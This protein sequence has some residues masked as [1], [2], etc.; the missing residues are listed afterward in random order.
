MTV[1]LHSLCGNGTVDSGQGEQ[2][3]TGI[4]G[5][6]CCNSTCHFISGGIVPSLR[7][8]LRRRGELLGLGGDLPGEH[9]R[10]ERDRVSRGHGR[11]L[12]RGRE[13]HRLDGSLSRLTASSAVLR[14]AAPTGVCDVVENCTGSSPNCPANAFA[15]SS[16]TCRP[17]AGV[18]DVA[19]NCTGSSAACPANTFASNST[20][21]P[22]RRGH[23]RPRGEL[24][25]L[26]RGVPRRFQE[27][28]ASAGRPAVSA[29]LRKP[30]TARA[31]RARRM[32][33]SPQRP[34]VV[35]RTAS[36]TSPRPA[37]ASASSARPT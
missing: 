28:Q 13:L 14:A 31:T 9:L 3:D 18:C 30:A 8:H 5:S 12:R 15:A 10:L 20:M 19:E 37:T 7:R 4:A 24:H 17:A 27:L 22:R 33:S 21:L 23:L 34:C 29:T 32:P 1:T 6:V 11:R 16:V 26:E 25:R 35:R 36:A 2:C